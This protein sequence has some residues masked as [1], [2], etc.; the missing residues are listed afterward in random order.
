VIEADES[1]GSFLALKSPAAIIT[2]IDADHLSYWGSVQALT[3]GFEAFARATAGPVVLCADDPG[4]AALA[5][6]NH[7]AITY[8]TAHSADYQILSFETLRAGVRFALVSGSERVEVAVDGAPGIHSARNATAALALAHQLGVDLAEG[9][10]AL[11]SFRGVAR[12]FEVRG[13]VN[14]ITFVDC[15]DHLPAEIEAAVAAARQGGW[16]RIVCVFQ[17]HRYSRTEALWRSFGGAF[18]GTD[19]LCVTDIYPA[20]ESPRP[21]VSGELIVQ[22][23]RQACPGLPVEYRPTLTEVASWLADVLRPGDLCLTLGAGDLTLVPD[24]VMRHLQSH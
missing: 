3:D 21:G 16:N 17:P 13:D 14:G 5:G 23:V 2:N 4:S 24:E 9:V 6:R 19:I 20:G 8:G 7:D 1:D 12:R 15:Y 22:A 10:E 11:R 18:G